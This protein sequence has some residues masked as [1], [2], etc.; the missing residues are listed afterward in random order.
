MQKAR[1]WLNQHPAAVGPVLV[2][3]V[4][5]GVGLVTWQTGV[6]QK[7]LATGPD[8]GG[9]SGGGATG[10]GPGGGGPGG[11]FAAMLRQH[12]QAFALG[13]FVRTLDEVDQEGKQPLTK[14]QAG[15]VLEVIRPLQKGTNLEEG[16]AKRALAKLQGLLTPDQ[17]RAVEEAQANGPGGPP[18]GGG[19]GGPAPRAGGP[20]PGAG[21]GPGGPAPTAGNEAP[22]PFNPLS[23]QAP[24]GN[25]RAQRRAARIKAFTARLEQRTAAS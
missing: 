9:Q 20:A 5:L 6:F 18:P 4:A 19:P 13:R 3:L 12:P 15:S 17:R 2:L 11:G 8:G 10:G 16:A 25:E 22:R 24:A 21:G 14:A 7:T 1:I 23:I